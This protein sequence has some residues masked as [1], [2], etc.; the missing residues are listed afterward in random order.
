M[1]LFESDKYEKQYLDNP[2]ISNDD[3]LYVGKLLN[4]ELL[5][6]KDHEDYL[7]KPQCFIKILKKEQF[8]YFCIN[9][10]SNQEISFQFLYKFILMKQ[11][12]WRQ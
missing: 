4:I 8:I 1:S 6:P 7:I 12:L 5:I 11:Y 9:T 3:L 10:F 2:K